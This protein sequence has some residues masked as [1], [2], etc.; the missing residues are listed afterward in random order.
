MWSP[1]CASFAIVH[2]SISLHEVLSFIATSNLRPPPSA[3]A[4]P[5]PASASATIAHESLPQL[6]RPLE[7]YQSTIPM[8]S[9]FEE[10]SK[11]DSNAA[12]RN[13]SIRAPKVSH[14]RELQQ[15]FVVWGF[16]RRFGEDGD[17]EIGE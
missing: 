10:L 16:G 2:V 6:P 3:P 8:Q 11:H 9:R 13:C 12:T 5:T 14:R 17:E 7:T 4:I 1:G 15:L